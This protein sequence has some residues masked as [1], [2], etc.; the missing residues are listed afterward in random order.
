M[1]LADEKEDKDADIKALVD[2]GAD[3]MKIYNKAG[4][5]DALD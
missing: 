2:S 3:L 5:N 4:K 1:S